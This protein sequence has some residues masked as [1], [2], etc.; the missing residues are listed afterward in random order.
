MRR[1]HDQLGL[2]R[3]RERRIGSSSS[4][5]L[6]RSRAARISARRVA[7]RTSGPRR[8]A[9]GVP[10]AVV[11]H[12]G[13]GRAAQQDHARDQQEDG[14][15]VGAGGGDQMA[16]DVVLGAAE[17][18]AARLRSRP[19]TRNR[20]SGVRPGPK[21]P[22]ANASA[23]ASSRQI[24]PLRSGR[25]AGATSMS[26]ASTRAPPSTSAIGVRYASLPISSS[27]PAHHAVTER[28]AGP[29]PIRDAAEED[30]DRDQRQRDH[31][32]LVRL[33]VAHAAQ[34]RPA[35]DERARGPRR[36]LLRR[37][38]LSAGGPLA[39]SRPTALGGRLPGLVRSTGGSHLYARSTSTSGGK[40][41]PGKLVRW[42]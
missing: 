3:A 32:D 4:S 19:P 35:R 2:A 1:A 40:A 27:R 13:E 17:Q 25:V 21:T 29:E 22:A 6:R 36:R 34:P 42:T 37:L 28:T 31:V 10:A 15:D 23:S 26:R 14:E 24:V 7:L 38:S 41:L 33:E 8:R 11:D 18:P 20:R 5:S 16:D 12:R 30:P 39:T 9:V